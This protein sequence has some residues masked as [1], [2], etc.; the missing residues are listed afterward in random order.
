MENPIK[1][2]I[3][4]DVDSGR[5]KPILFSKP[6]GIQPPTNR[7]EAA[8]MLLTDINCMAQGITTL[9]RVAGNNQYADTNE[10]INATIKTLYE[11]LETSDKTASESESN[12]EH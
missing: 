1:T 12:N 2:T 4:L 3:I 6:N 11:A 9:I 7:E 5:E 10:L 8:K